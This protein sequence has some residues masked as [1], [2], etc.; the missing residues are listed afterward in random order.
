MNESADV[1]PEV[2][3]LY[4]EIQSERRAASTARGPC[5]CAIHERCPEAVRLRPVH[6]AVREATS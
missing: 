1:T 4:S 3:R 6:S 5:G 2:Q